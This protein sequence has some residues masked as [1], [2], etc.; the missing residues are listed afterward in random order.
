[1]YFGKE[2]TKLQTKSLPWIYTPKTDQPNSFGCEPKG[3][4]SSYRLSYTSNDAAKMECVSQED[5]SNDCNYPV[6]SMDS[7]PCI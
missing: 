4:T 6:Q 3:P 1:M 5:L 2:P 7:L